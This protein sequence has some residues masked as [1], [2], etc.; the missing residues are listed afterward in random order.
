MLLHR[1]F[2]DD[3]HKLGKPLHVLVNNA[4][5]H[6]KVCLCVGGGGGGGA[7]TV[8]TQSDGVSRSDKVTEALCHRH[9]PTNLWCMLSL[10]MLM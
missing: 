7:N 10:V 5:V 4:G 3:F 6:L 2:A 9:V 8:P 1:K